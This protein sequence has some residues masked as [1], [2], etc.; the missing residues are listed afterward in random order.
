MSL[1]QSEAIVVHSRKQGETS[2]ILVLY[3]Q[4][5]GKITAMAKGSRTTKSRYLGVLEPFN[6]IS[7]VYYQKDTR[8]IQYISSAEIINHFP[9]IHGNLKKMALA[10]IPC[11]IIERAEENEHENNRLF[12]L[13]LEFL[14]ALEQQENGLLNF[15]Q[16]FQ[17]KFLDIAGFKPQLERCNNCHRTDA[18]EFQFFSLENG[19]Y[20]CGRCVPGVETGIR[21]SAFALENLRWY[22]STPLSQAFRAKINARTG[23]EIDFFLLS[24]LR[25]HI[26]HLQ[27][28]KSL[29]Y[30]EKLKASLSQSQE[31]IMS[32]KPQ[33]IEEKVN[34]E[35][36]K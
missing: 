31:G 36:I 5:A 12:R 29:E 19:A 35:K 10:A 32:D 15:V 6:H 14:T 18:D 9:G 21:L 8:D 20:L 23:K 24:N 34:G 17:I 4:R 25:Y 30:I 28:L 1:I 11:E 16:S 13:L 2:K 26:E 22:S 33:K 3:T 7:M 27:Y